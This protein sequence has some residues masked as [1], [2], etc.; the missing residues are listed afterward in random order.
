MLENENP[1][2][3][4]PDHAFFADVQTDESQD[5]RFKDQTVRIK[6]DERR[7][8]LKPNVGDLGF[9]QVVLGK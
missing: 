3:R 7:R 2:G 5:E 1:V 4:Q 8:A 9:E 6:H